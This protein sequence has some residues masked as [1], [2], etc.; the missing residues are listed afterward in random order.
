MRR[1]LEHEGH[2]L[3]QLSGAIAE[4]TLSP[5]LAAEHPDLT[6]E[7]IAAHLLYLGFVWHELATWLGYQSFPGFPET[8]SSFSPD[9]LVS[10]LLGIELGRKLLTSPATAVEQWNLLLDVELRRLL[11]DNGALPGAATREVFDGIEGDW[12]DA[13]A[14]LPALEL[15]RRRNLQFRGAIEPW[16]VATVSGCDDDMPPLPMPT[17]EIPPDIFAHVE[18]IITPDADLAEVVGTTVVPSDLATLVDRVRAEMVDRLGPRS[19]TPP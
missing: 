9:D 3:F 19:A 13:S 15:V 7:E 6:I 17:P 14:V 1:L 16:L 8:N 12:W 18:I 2:Q 10:D 4:V 5:L 11:N